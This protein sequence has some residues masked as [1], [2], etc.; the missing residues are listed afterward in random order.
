MLYVE[1]PLSVGFSSGGPLPQNETNVAEDFYAFLQN[2]FE[3]FVL[4]Q[5][6]EFHLFGESYAGM[7]VPS[8]ARYIYGQNLMLVTGAASTNENFDT[9]RI[10]L[11]GIGIGN[12][13][14][15]SRVQGPIRIDFAYFHG[16]I[17]SYTRDNLHLLW[18]LC[19]DP[20]NKMEA[21]IHSFDVPDDCGLLIAIP[22]AA[23]M[24]P[25]GGGPN[26]Y[27]VTTWDTY[28]VLDGDD[29][30]MSRFLNNPAVKEKLHAPAN[31]FWRGCLPGAGRRK[32]LQEQRRHL[33]TS[34]LLHDKPISTLPYI[35]E[36]LDGGVR[37]LM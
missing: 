2:F 27:D 8:I 22:L 31:T 29:N 16:L 30:T 4:Y 11:V 9:I 15:D 24:G 7:Y 23:G 5:E 10:P 19:I 36:L 33:E 18:S 13:L 35:G 17:D 1:Q 26:V 25:A 21:P 28:A 20:T 6:Y 37:V 32:L 14:V 12:G 34:L 3:T